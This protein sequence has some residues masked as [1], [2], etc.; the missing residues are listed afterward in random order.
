MRYIDFHTH[1]FT[2]QIAA[3]AIASLQEGARRSGF[4]DT[5]Y[6]DGTAGG[7]CSLMD[8][9][10]IECSVLLSV[11]T[12]PSQPESINQWARELAQTK[13]GRIIPFGAVFPDESAVGCI[14]TLAENGIK[15]IKLHGDFQ[16]FYADEE[17]MLDIYR[18]CAELGM[19]VVMHSGIDCSSPDDVHV[20]PERLARIFDKVS[21]VRF[22]LA[23]MGGVGFEY[24]TARLLRGADFFVDT[25]Y[26]A[27]RLEP[28]DMRELVLQYGAQRV[29]FA[30]D[31]PWN[32]PQDIIALI[33]K[34]GLSEDEKKMIFSRNAL[35]LLGKAL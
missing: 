15:G 2:D 13:Q 27:G 14:E 35:R 18:R 8:R 6:S 25:A 17:R 28:E 33:E 20:T 11:A 30:S 34:A 23:H 7:L 24:E 5:A 1:A 21:G 29:L 9:C 19:L 31:S 4:D 12:K 26:T 10:G 22:V 3:K 32:D 16:G